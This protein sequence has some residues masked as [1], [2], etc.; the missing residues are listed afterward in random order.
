MFLRQWIARLLFD[1]FAS[2]V[3]DTLFFYASSLMDYPLFKWFL[4][5]RVTLLKLKL[6]LD[7]NF[8]ILFD[9]YSALIGDARFFFSWVGFFNVDY[10]LFSD[11]LTFF[12]LLFPFFGEFFFMLLLFFCEIFLPL[13][14]FFRKFFLMYFLYFS[15][16]LGVVSKGFYQLIIC[17][18]IFILE[19]S[20]FLCQGQH[21]LFLFLELLFQ[22]F[23]A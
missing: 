2:R 9:L 19:I 22:S 12:V 13:L 20:G 21:S 5:C 4:L 16:L 18:L 3:L 11:V 14:S 1:L 7:V 15:D 6:R 17:F 23:D 10:F 8:G